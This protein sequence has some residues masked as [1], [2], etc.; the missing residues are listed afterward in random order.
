[1]DTKKKTRETKGVMVCTPTNVLLLRV[2]LVSRLLFADAL[3]AMREISAAA[4]QVT[5]TSES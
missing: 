5:I 3:I 2:S 4:R 1:M